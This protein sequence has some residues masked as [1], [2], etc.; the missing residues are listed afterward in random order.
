MNTPFK[1]LLVGILL[2]A[3][4]LSC[5]KE[6][7]LTPKERFLSA[8]TWVIT[9][10]TAQLG[11]RYENK[12]ASLPACFKDDI[13]VFSS[14][15]QYEYNAGATKC[16]ATDP[17]VIHTGIWSLSDDG[18]SLKINIK[19]GDSGLGLYEYKVTELSENMLQLQII[20]GGITYRL[21]FEH[22]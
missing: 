14:N 18:S 4:T 6:P 5:T 16:T 3:T 19:T 20:D 17:Q 21:L 8:K 10:Y 12:F 7:S 9:A 11:S 15:K 1:S 2:V 13:Y 22:P